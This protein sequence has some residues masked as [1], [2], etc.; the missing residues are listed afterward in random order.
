MNQELATQIKKQVEF[1]FSDSNFRRDRFLQAETKKQQDGF[2]PFQVLFTFKKLAALTTEEEILKKAI[3]H[4]TIVELND[5]KNALRRRFDLPKEDLTS[6][7]TLVLA[8]LGSNFPTIDEIK[9]AFTK[10]YQVELMYIDRKRFHQRFSGIVHVEFQTIDDLNKVLND[11]SKTLSILNHKPSMMVLKEYLALSKED[12]IE[13]NKSIQA[14]LVSTSEIPL[15]T[16]VSFFQ[17]ELLSIWQNQPEIRPRIKYV[18]GT[19][20]LYLIFS[21]KHFAEQVHELLKTT[22]QMIINEKPIEFELITDENQIKSRPRS[23]NKDS[24]KNKRKQRDA[25]EEEGRI[26]HITNIGPKV[27]LEEV[28]KLITSVMEDGE[29]SPFIEYDGL[30]HAKFK[31]SNIDKAQ[32]IFTKLNDLEKK[33]LG[34]KQVKFHLLEPKEE[35]ELEIEYEKG[36]V[37]RFE[38]ESTA[39]STD[40]QQLSREEIKQFLNDQLEDKEN[41]GIAFIKYQQG[42]TSGFLRVTSTKIANQ[43]LNFTNLIINETKITKIVLVQDEEEKQFWTDAYNARRHRFKQTRTNKNL[44]KRH[45]QQRRH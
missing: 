4:S 10:A 38:L 22:N 28:K 19:N 13:F 21:Q 5:Q 11:K 40:Q 9:Q 31:I 15:N 24:K 29:S 32:E 41:D 36:L 23:E 12:Q 45:G 27:R 30:D 44:I 1:Y 2:I 25:E 18:D 16:P 34:G 14:M 42:E 6:E 33:E 43:I 17:D 7:R 37:L 3:E 39:S 20:Q 35:L 26:I 8:G